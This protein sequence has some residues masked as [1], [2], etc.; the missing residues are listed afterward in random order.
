MANTESMNGD[1]L[2]RLS[3]AIF[4]LD[5]RLH[6]QFLNEAAEELCGHSRN[7]CLGVAFSQLFTS[8]DTDSHTFEDCVKNFRK[9]VI[10]EVGFKVHGQPEKTRADLYL[11]PNEDGFILVELESVDRILRISEEDHNLSIQASSQTLL[12][13]IAHELRNPLGGIRGAAQLL[14]RNVSSANDI[15]CAELILGEVDRLQVLLDKML[16]P[17][18]TVRT[19]S[20]N[21]HEVL[22]HVV[23]VLQADPR[24]KRNQTKFIHKYDPSV[25]ELKGD[26]DLIQQALMNITLNGLEALVDVEQPTLTIRTGVELDFTIGKVRHAYVIRI[27]IEDNGPGVDNELQDQIFM[28]MISSKPKSS[29]L[30]L[31]ITQAIIAT[32]SG[33]VTCNSKQG[34]TIFSIFLPVAGTGR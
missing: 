14:H 33:L 31:A 22:S 29:G 26:P 30:G 20:L 9:V 2:N 18:Q 4:L 13:G 8:I 28:P 34:R 25:P 5:D 32:H 7:Y 12:Q 19:E 10:R 1:I 27:Q 3:R 16:S 23:R 24:F 17:Q 11:T 21:V 15:E 6:V